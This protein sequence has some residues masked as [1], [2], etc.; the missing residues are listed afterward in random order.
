MEYHLTTV[1]EF[2]LSQQTLDYKKECRVSFGAYVQAHRKLTYIN[3]NAPHTLDA[4]TILPVISLYLVRSNNS[5]MQTSQLKMQQS[6]MKHYGDLDNS[7]TTT[8][9]NK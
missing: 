3:S 7:L 8:A 4:D 6:Y 1:L 2:L 9:S 5:M